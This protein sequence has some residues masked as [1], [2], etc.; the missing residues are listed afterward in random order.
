MAPVGSSTTFLIA[1]AVLINFAAA[2]VPS[3]V[4]QGATVGVGSNAASA[5]TLGMADSSSDSYDVVKVDLDDE[6]D[7]PIYIGAEFDEAEG[8]EGGPFFVA[9][10][11]ERNSVH[12]NLMFL[13]YSV[14]STISCFELTI[15]I[16]IDLRTIKYLHRQ[17]ERFCDHTSREIVL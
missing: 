8:E 9:I 12:A 13:V 14:Y 4:H 17:L 11:H 6:R 1:A 7:Y 15:E 16:G 5:T 3:S 10:T 2:F